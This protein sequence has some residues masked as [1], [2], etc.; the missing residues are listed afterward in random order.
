MAERNR[1]RR[2]RPPAKSANP[3]GFLGLFERKKVEFKEDSLGTGIIQKLYMTRQQRLTLLRWFSLSMVCIMATVLQDS[4]FSRFRIFGAYTDLA[5]AAILLV[6]VVEGTET[7]SIFVLIASIIY[8]FTGFAP[9]PYVVASLPILGLFAT[10]FR[11]LYW[12]R[13]QGTILLCGW[14]AQM[15]H[16]IV[17]FVASYLSGLTLLDRLPRFLL[18]GVYGCIA[19]ALLYP[20]VNRLGKIGGHTWKE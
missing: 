4:L 18:T 16:Q 5:A 9:G 14:I 6:T 8:Y 20:L 15:G 17:V 7:G 13:S 10:M 12:H 3:L 1:Y 19:M 2:R 11:Q